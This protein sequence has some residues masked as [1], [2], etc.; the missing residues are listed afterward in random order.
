MF[1]SSDLYDS[2]TDNDLIRFNSYVN[3]VA[4]FPPKRGDG[5]SLIFI[6]TNDGKIHVFSSQTRESLRTL[7]GHTANGM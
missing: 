6:G 1:F 5:P 2:A 7:E 4:V 3:S